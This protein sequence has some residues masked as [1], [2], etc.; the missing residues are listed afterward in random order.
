MTLFRDM[1]KAYQALCQYDCRKAIQLF[2]DLPLQHAN[3]G[4]VLCQ[5]GRA[6]FEIAEY[7]KVSS[8]YLHFCVTYDYL[9][10]QSLSDDIADSPRL[11]SVLPSGR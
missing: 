11:K 3:T 10:Y 5:I 1:G 6:Y 4:W 8:F 9:C 7:K 2:S